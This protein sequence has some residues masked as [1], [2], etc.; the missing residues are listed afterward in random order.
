MPPFD[1]VRRS[2][3]PKDTPVNE[4]KP[5]TQTQGSP[6]SEGEKPAE[7]EKDKKIKKR[8]P[9][10]R[11]SE[12]SKVVSGGANRRGQAEP[13]FKPRQNMTPGEV[14]KLFR[15]KALTREGIFNSLNQHLQREAATQLAKLGQFAKTAGDGKASSRQELAKSVTKKVEDVFSFQKIAQQDTAGQN[16]P[17]FKRWTWMI[18]NGYSLGDE[19]THYSKTPPRGDKRAGDRD[20]IVKE[21][22]Q[23]RP[24]LEAQI[25]DKIGEEFDLIAKWARAKTHND[26]LPA[27]IAEF[28][29]LNPGKSIDFKDARYQKTRDVTFP[30]KSLVVYLNV[31]IILSELPVGKIVKNIKEELLQKLQTNLLKDL[32]SLPYIPYQPVSQTKKVERAKIEQT[33]REAQPRGERGKNPVKEV[34]TQA[35]LDRQAKLETLITETQARKSKI[36]VFHK[37]FEK[38]LRDAVGQL[39]DIGERIKNSAKAHGDFIADASKFLPAA[40]TRGWLKKKAGSQREIGAL[41]HQHEFERLKK[42]AHDV[43]ERHWTSLQKYISDIV[44]TLPE[45]RELGLGHVDLDKME[46][47]NLSTFI[48]TLKKASDL[49]KKPRG[50]ETSEG[51]RINLLKVIP[52]LRDELKAVSGEDKKALGDRR[53]LQSQIDYLEALTDPKRYVGVLKNKKDK[54]VADKERDERLQ[55][56]AARY[57]SRGLYKSK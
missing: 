34:E 40:D 41:L 47:R 9:P 52:R 25:V 20:K 33:T 51:R 28:Q 38:Y 13:V 5:E 26:A 39:K 37:E 35:S 53:S 11:R 43:E 31:D 14:N 30:T 16:V 8:R 23:R 17:L 57:S 12:L 19:K 50:P 48:S 36:D 56:A 4:K 15:A 42:D 18:S 21:F 54:A 29:R 24:E 45:V 55:K 22:E 44:R 27:K 32:G 10:G 3:K 1:R 46:A 2:G 6:N 49:I 7:I